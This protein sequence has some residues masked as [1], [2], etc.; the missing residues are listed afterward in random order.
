MGPI[1]L[2]VSTN[3]PEYFAGSVVEG[4]VSVEVC[5]VRGREAHLH[6]KVQGLP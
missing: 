3:Q 2:K 6:F 1:K 5:T 4:N